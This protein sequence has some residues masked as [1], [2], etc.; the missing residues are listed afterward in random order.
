LHKIIKDYPVI[1]EA[2]PNII[3]LDQIP[4]FR[5]ITSKLF[6]NNNSFKKTDKEINILPD[7]VTIKLKNK[8][9]SK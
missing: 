5:I 9:F 6:K 1:V 4:K 2:N 8:D 3:N 7:S